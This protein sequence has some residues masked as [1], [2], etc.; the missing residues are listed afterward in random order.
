MMSRFL[1]LFR[2]LQWQLTLLYIMT[3]L[4]AALIVALAT[5]AASALIPAKTA[6]A[7]PAEILTNSMAFTEA[8]HIA[9]YL[10]QSPPDQRGL[11]GWAAT[12][13]HG[14]TFSKQGFRPNPSLASAAG[15]TP[16]LAPGSDGA[17]GVT[18]L[19]FDRDGQLVASDP[20]AAS[21]V[22]ELAT[23]PIAQLGL[24]S[25]L[26][27]DARQGP[28]FKTSILA[29]GRT[30]ACVPVVAY[31][32]GPLLGALLVAATITPGPQAATTV[33]S[34]LTPEDVLGAIKGAL[35]LT[36]A[37]VALASVI[38]TFVGVVAS[39]RITHRLHSITVA[40]DAWSQ[41]EFQTTVRDAGHDELG[42]LAADLNTM[43]QQ[44]QRLVIARQE[45]AVV[46]ERHRLARDL[47]DSVKQQTFVIT[48]LVGAARNLVT[49]NAE[50]ERMLSEAE[51]LAGQTQQELTTLI[52]TLRPIALKDTHLSTALREFCGDWTQLTHIDVQLDVPD[53][54]PVAPNAEQELFRVAQEALANVARHSRAT[55]VVVRACIEGECALLSIQ[56]NGLG[57]DLD[58]ISGVGL[59]LRSMR[60]RVE[61]LGGSLTILSGDVGTRVEARIPVFAQA[62]PAEAH[63]VA[64]NFIAAH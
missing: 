24:R 13:T 43:A 51:R 63:D 17:R 60:E 7:T 37:L 44:L 61:T 6:I 46:E 27:K 40:A 58:Q 35:P 55:E 8:P 62:I 19:I 4:V 20:S 38:G 15:A 1:M 10:E 25:A 36:L 29:D 12:W 22:S 30:V 49:G 21:S 64:T 50:A 2:R 34:P 32:G 23:N 39:R 14:F 26:V 5:T 42:A 47:H 45:L 33:N 41:G 53:E 48:M 16:E 31:D 56:D 3:T 59:G 11:D 54:L 18:V 9:A 57:F 52:R 28:Y